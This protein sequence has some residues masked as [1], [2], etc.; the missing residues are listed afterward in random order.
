MGIP[1][2]LNR[3]VQPHGNR[4]GLSVGWLTT[5]WLSYIVSAGDHR[6]VEVEPWVEAQQETVS[7]LIPES[8]GPKDFTD[9]R[10][11]DVL[12]LLSQDA[13]WAAIEVELGQHL[14]RVYDL[15]DE[16]IRLDSTSVSVYHEAAS[17]PL[18]R[19]GHSKDH[20]PD[21]A[22]FKLMLGTLDP[23]GMPL[24]SLV[25]AGN[26][27]DDPL[28]LP[29][30]MQARQV[31]GSGQKLYIG[32]TKMGALATRAVIH[33]GGDYYLTPLAQ[34]GE[35]PQ[36][37]QQ[38]L[39][40][41]WAG[42]QALQRIEGVDEWGAGPKPTEP[43]ALALA[44]EVD[45]G[46]QAWVEEQAVRW[47][48]RVLVVH[49]P[50]LART[51]QRGLEGRLSRAEA[52]LQ[53]LTPPR[54]RGK[55]QWT[56]RPALEAAVQTILKKHRVEGLL[57][58]SYTHQVERRLIRPYK[59][60][61][62][63]QEERSRYTVAIQP[64]T[65]AIEQAGRLLGWRLYVTNAPAP[66][67][68]LAEAIQAYRGA[69]HIER[70]FARLKGRALGIRP[71]YVQREDHAKGMVRLLSLALRVLTLTEYVVR[72]KLHAAG[73][74]LTGLYAGNPKRQTAR[75]TTER[76]LK[77]FKGI[78]LTVVQLP[79]QTIRHVTPLSKLQRWI[80]NLLGLP[81]SIYEKL[82]LPEEPIPI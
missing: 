75:P 73:E 62:A 20:R 17:Q 4:Q 22:Q 68:A 2:I 5:T 33:Q 66:A 38:L 25:V 42:N 52:A 64:Q 34:V 58:V 77:A 40:P 78:V 36:L 6:M 80:L 67:L 7:R 59:E 51:G 21:L 16:R 74:T 23:L 82:T 37:L 76:L 50:A 29:A 15:A 44:F 54:G 35:V 63:R 46:Q 13:I 53:A 55:K 10:L 45:R 26:S 41:V 32:D 69:P 81:D 39:H 72:Q 28:Y 65:E 70:N 3:V 57:E 30:L 71:L 48:E 18:F 56:D 11:A 27:A 43:E 14:I 9:D 61:P 60:R 79:D 24:A 8:M 47:D 49:S 12:G 1:Q 31:V 19:T